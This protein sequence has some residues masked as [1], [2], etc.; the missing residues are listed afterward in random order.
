[1]DKST[2][3]YFNVS[4]KENYI[5]MDILAN[6]LDLYCST[7]ISKLIIENINKHNKSNIILDIEKVTYMDSSFISRLIDINRKLNTENKKLYLTSVNED[8]MA[9]FNIANLHQMF[10]IMKSKEEAINSI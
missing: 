8:V 10:N 5:T 7:E 1:M 3:K 9:I 2:N 4:V 6:E